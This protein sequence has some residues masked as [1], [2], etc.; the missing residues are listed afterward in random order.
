[1]SHIQLAARHFVGTQPVV[2]TSELHS[3]DHPQNWE[4]ALSSHAESV[5]SMLMSLDYSTQEKAIG[6][7]NTP[8]KQLSEADA[9][10][11]TDVGANIDNVRQEYQSALQ[12]PRKG[13]FNNA[14]QYQ[15]QEA[16]D[17]F[18]P[19]DEW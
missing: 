12:T 4:N 15:K 18:A 3:T 2:H 5:R 1:M 10:I 11:F 13:L 16:D 9:S 7:L 17:G 14:E 8:A 19:Q 6:Y